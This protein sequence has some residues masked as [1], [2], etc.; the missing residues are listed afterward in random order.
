[1]STLITGALGQIGSQ[2]RSVLAG[3]VISLDS[4]DGAGILACDVRRPLMDSTRNELAGVKRVLHLAGSKANLP[5]DSV[6][7]WNATEANAIGTANLLAALP[8]TV[9]HVVVVS[10]I[11][12]YGASPR[13]EKLSE[14]ATL[15]P[16]SAY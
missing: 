9:E 16:R 13:G 7:A 6:S 14:D 15:Q 4:R 5:F 12:V 1:M 10:S 3:Q 11:S 2:C 8:G